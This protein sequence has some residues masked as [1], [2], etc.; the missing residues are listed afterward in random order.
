MPVMNGIEFYQY[1]MSKRPEL[2]EKV[3]L[4][5]GYSGIEIETASHLP[6]IP[7]LRKPISVKNLFNIFSDRHDNS[8]SQQELKGN[9]A[10]NPSD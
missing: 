8:P 10:K 4:M 6:H 7:I 1:L 2:I 9:E 3:I 5:S